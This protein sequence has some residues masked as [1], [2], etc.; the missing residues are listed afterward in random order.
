MWKW[1]RSLSFHTWWSVSVHD[2]YVTSCSLPF[3]T[4]SLIKVWA[5]KLCPSLTLALRFADSVRAWKTAGFEPPP[6]GAVPFL[7]LISLMR[8]GANL[9][10]SLQENILWR[11]GSWDTSQISVASGTPSDKVMEGQGGA[12]LKIISFHI[13]SILK[14][15]ICFASSGKLPKV[16]W[17]RAKFWNFSVLEEQRTGAHAHARTH[18]YTRF[19]RLLFWL[20]SQTLCCPKLLPLR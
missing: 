12:L 16:P 20:W 15:F 7:V 17:S 6:Q 9:Q 1:R 3:G 11:W 4:F 18:A 2:M 8:W 13:R 19:L 14:Y 10:L 5:W